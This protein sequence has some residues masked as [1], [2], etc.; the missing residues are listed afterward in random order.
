MVCLSILDRRRFNCYIMFMLNHQPPWFSGLVMYQI[1][2][3][4][5][6]DSTGDGVGDLNG[7]IE[8]LDYLNG[9]P[10]SLGIDAIWLSPFYPS[11]MADFGY[12]VTNYCDVDPLF[13]SLADFER[14]VKEAHYRGIRV[15]VDLVPNHTSD[16][17]PWF[18]ESR[19]SR[20][21]PKRDWYTWRDP[22]RDGSEPN[23]WLSVFGGSAWEFDK[24]TGQYYLHTFLSKQPDLNWRNPEV[25]NAI[26][27]A[28]RF[29]LHLGVDGFRV[30]AVLGLS[31]DRDLR[32]NPINEDYDPK[33]DKD[34][35]HA[36]KPINSSFGS[37]LFPYLR[38]MADV[39]KPYPHSFMVTEYYPDEN[40]CVPQRIDEYIKFYD[41]VDADVSAPINF[42]G[43]TTDWD[44][45]Q[46]GTHIEEFQRAMGYR[47]S[48]VYCL[49][50][51][52][53]SR[54]ATRFGRAAARVAAVIQLTLPG[55]PIIYYGDEL[56][57][58]DGDVPADKR[59]DPFAINQI[60]IGLNRDPE[61]TPMLWDDGP[62]AGFTKSSSPWLPINSDHK[63]CNVKT[64]LRDKKSFLN[65]YRQLIRVRKSSEALRSGDFAMVSSDN[66]ILGYRRFR[67]DENVLIVANFDSKEKT[68]EID[69]PNRGKLVFSS[70]GS[71]SHQDHTT[72]VTLAP[73]EAVI[74]QRKLG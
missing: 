55:M 70:V 32:D 59:R 35:Y 9:T 57:M 2:P 30:D 18:K 33:T 69:E 44:A 8:K 68:Y 23:N 20:D 28:M 56:G 45:K 3:R 42:E 65:L 48:P 53:K 6:C 13:G 29:W 61:R 4:S 74:I 37:K 66:G 46:F 19:S 24:K 17:H 11:P 64:E 26:F 73:H 16:E 67:G 36:L 38:E 63:Q 34:T 21:N 43:A 7:I 62:Q 40:G 14:L 47:Y 27:D 25:R 12:D 52:D 22:K 1:Y 41:Y 31:K 60:G 58:I 71:A 15:V 51:H 10:D 72:S 39:L 5:F 49:G 54:L 50:N